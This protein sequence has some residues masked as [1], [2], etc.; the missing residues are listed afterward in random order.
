MSLKPYPGAIWSA[1][2]DA[3]DD[4]V[5]E[6][7]HLANVD[8]VARATLAS[9]KRLHPRLFTDRFMVEMHAEGFGGMVKTCK[10]VVK[11]SGTLNQWMRPT[12]PNGWEQPLWY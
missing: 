2:R 1:V 6:L 9:M 7:G 12:R 8:Q 11:L 5:K 10:P 4:A 3:Q